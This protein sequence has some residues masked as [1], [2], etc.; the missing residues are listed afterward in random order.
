MNKSG[1]SVLQKEHG[2]PQAMCTVSPDYYCTEGRRHIC[3]DI[4]EEK[5]NMLQV[6]RGVCFHYKDYPPKKR[7]FKKVILMLQSSVCRLF[8]A[9][10]NLTG[11]Y[12]V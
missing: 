8:Q 5:E 11:L 9:S 7:V 3:W 2:Q 10:P 1:E 6:E 12:P 4:Q